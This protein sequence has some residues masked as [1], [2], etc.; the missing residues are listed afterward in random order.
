MLITTIKAHKGHVKIVPPPQQL[1]PTPYPNRNRHRRNTKNSTPDM[2]AI[3]HTTRM[4][5]LP[6]TLPAQSPPAVGRDVKTFH[7][8]IL[9]K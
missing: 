6:S 4:S 7:I 2:P 3:K 9:N 8:K 1:P 5:G